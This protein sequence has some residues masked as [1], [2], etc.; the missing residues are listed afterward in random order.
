M[1][2]L[3]PTKIT[4]HQGQTYTMFV[5]ADECFGVKRVLLC[6]E[7]EHN[8]TNTDYVLFTTLVIDT[9]F[10]MLLDESIHCGVEYIN[11]VL[12]YITEHKDQVRNVLKDFLSSAE[13][14][15]FLEQIRPAISNHNIRETREY[16]VLEYC[17][18][19]SRAYRTEQKNFYIL[20]EHDNFQHVGLGVAATIFGD[21]TI[22]DRCWQ[23]D[24]LNGMGHNG[25]AAWL[26]GLGIQD[27]ARDRRNNG[28]CC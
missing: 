7:M 14:E 9:R 18:R 17:D 6:F 8:Q 21:D 15:N 5:H 26:D 20:D 1:V 2:K 24:F 3:N 4:D 16:T 11:D 22:V 28:W 13:I 25:R 10:C 27:I 19:P 12:Q 23:L